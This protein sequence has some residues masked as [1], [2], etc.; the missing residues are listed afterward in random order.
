ML[1]LTTLIAWHDSG[2][3]GKVCEKPKENK[4]C[5]SFG[6]VKG[7]K[8]NLKWNCEQHAGEEKDCWEPCINEINIFSFKKNL[9]PDCPHCRSMGFG[10]KRI[11][12]DKDYIENFIFPR[13]RE[14]ESLIFLYCRE[15]PFSE[16]K[17]ICGCVKPGRL[18]TGFDEKDRPIV[19][20]NISPED[21]IFIIPYQ[22]LY[23]ELSKVL[24]VDNYPENCVFKVPSDLKRNFMS[25]TKTLNTP[26]TITLLNQAVDV[27][28]NINELLTKHPKYKDSLNY[29]KRQI[30]IHQYSERITKEIQNL[31]KA[32]PKYPG[33]PAILAF[34]GAVGSFKIYL[35]FLSKG[36]E[37]S[38]KNG[39]I[40]ALKNKLPDES[41]KLR[42][43]EIDGFNEKAKDFQKLVTERLIFYDIDRKQIEEISKQ[44]E[45]CA[46]LSENPYLISEDFKPKRAIKKNDIEVQPIS[47]FTIDKGENLR[48]ED[49][50]N[51]VSKERIRA[52]F[53]A[54]LKDALE[55]GHTTLPEENFRKYYNYL[56]KRLSSKIDIDETIEKIDEHRDF[57]AEK[58]II[59]DWESERF[60][61]LK[62]IREHEKEIKKF[63]DHL[64]QK[65]YQEKTVDL[66]KIKNE[67]Y[68]S[69]P[70][71]MIKEEYENGIA[72]QAEAISLILKNGI[73]IVTG[74]AG[75]GK[76]TLV[77]TIINL[78]KESEGLETC[79]T[80]LVAPTGKA[81]MRL[82]EAT[83]CDT[84]TI[85]R[86]LAKEGAF[87]FGYQRFKPN[88]QKDFDFVLID[89]ASM[90]DT[91]LLWA[92]I[93]S[94]ETKRLVM[95]GDVNQL[96]PVNA[97]KP[98]F[99]LKRYLEDK[100]NH[101]AYLNTVFRQEAREIVK[102]SNLF[103]DENPDDSLISNII[104]KFKRDGKYEKK[105]KDKKVIHIEPVEKGNREE[106]LQEVITGLVKGKNDFYNR[107]VFQ[108]EIQILT[109]MKTS[110]S[111]NSQNINY[112]IRDDS[113]FSH[114]GRNIIFFANGVMA[115]K[116]I[117]T[118]NDWQRK[119]YNANTNVPLIE[120]GVFNGMMGYA[121]KKRSFKAI[122]FFFP[123]NAEAYL[124]Q[125]EVEHAF[126]ITVHKAQ[127]SEWDKTI[128][129]FPKSGRLLSR[130]LIYTAI[131]RA[132][133]EVC[134]LLE[135]IDDFFSIKRS[136]IAERKTALFNLW[137]GNNL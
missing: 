79:S 90:V 128:L 73:T 21:V 54:S 102:F 5:E 65:F 57:L 43:N 55:D 110:G 70:E 130:E 80:L 4:Y 63:V 29:F 86:F 91:E 49:G 38:F 136:V 22:E 53:V 18:E 61:S 96:P 133:S 32:C 76:T 13:I 81:A 20:S 119:L 98:F 82:K 9:P 85:H 19:K 75:S 132:R 74:P 127:G 36:K 113:K 120:K 56:N 62:I 95:V 108:D 129:I 40:N 59:D 39:L 124:N 14:S 122:R 51:L 92:F 60:F 34:L 33:I 42:R 1:H 46:F 23:Q 111:L 123:K 112:F 101:I 105:I 26:D 93:K 87:D 44:F 121:V 48:L 28:D 131:T 115:D 8:Y 89:E 99:D 68:S 71:G 24:G 67:L 117:Q 64:I 30:D 35:D 31:D 103:I 134:L 94:I 69:V 10:W 12:G 116:V 2:W 77:K 78:L 135:G 97:G 137:P 114:G 17:I 84:K 47:F 7:K 15:N 109:P 72:S 106:K 11:Y 37:E 16:D 41:I 25:M 125:D 27:L 83:G 126:C 50:F 3:N 52:F 6:Y 118:K 66:D 45:N 107:F 58:V 104:S 100:G 88:E